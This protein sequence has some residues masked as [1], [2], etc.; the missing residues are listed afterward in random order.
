MVTFIARLKIRPG[1]REEALNRAR[2]MFEGV[3]QEEP[4]ALIYLGHQT[5]SDPDTLVFF[6][7]YADQQAAE[8]HEQ[9][10]HFQQLVQDFDTVFDPDFGVQIEYLDRLGGVVRT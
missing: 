2:A 7:V 4:G 6:E 8:I 3:R 1:M 5:Q 9:T 10:R